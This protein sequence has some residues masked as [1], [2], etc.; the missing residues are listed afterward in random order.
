MLHK[1]LSGKIRDIC[2]CRICSNFV[3]VRMYLQNKLRT[4]FSCPEEPASF[5]T[6]SI[7]DNAVYV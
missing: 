6:H 7:V 5:L 3:Y 4:K 2:D 1:N